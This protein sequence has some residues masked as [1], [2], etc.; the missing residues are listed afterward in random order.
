MKNE[1]KTFSSFSKSKL[2]IIMNTGKKNT[3]IM[4][5]IDLNPVSLNKSVDT[6]NM[7]TKDK[8]SNLFLF[9]KL[10]AFKFIHLYVVLIVKRGFSCKVS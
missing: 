1:K 4:V 8:I 10:I 6:T 2:F 7:I 3:I 5:N 9:N